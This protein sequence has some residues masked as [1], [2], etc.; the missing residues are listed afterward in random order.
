MPSGWLASSHATQAEVFVRGPIGDCFYVAG[1]PDQPLLLAGT[2]TGLAPLWGIL[3]SALASGHAGPIELWHG[4]RTT[5]G[6]YLVRELEALASA[7]RQLSYRRCVLEGPA[8]AGTEV[9]SLD[10][11][12]LASATS[13]DGRRVFLCGDPQLVQQLKRQVFMKGASMREIHA[14]AFVRATV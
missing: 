1:N 10:S 5:E 3:H 9:G 4:A 7:H 8:G 14:D 2:G 6:L 13:F 11:A 12:L